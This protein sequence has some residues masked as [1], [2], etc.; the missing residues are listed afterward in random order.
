MR[1]KI[2]DTCFDEGHCGRSN[3]KKIRRRRRKSLKFQDNQ[4]NSHTPLL[5]CAVQR[6]LRAQI[7]FQSVEETENLRDRGKCTMY[8]NRSLLSTSISYCFVSGIIK[9]DNKDIKRIEGQQA[10]LVLLLSGVA[11]V[12]VGL[13]QVKLTLKFSMPIQITSLEIYDYRH[14][15]TF[16]LH[17]MTTWTKLR[18]S[19]NL[20][21]MLAQAMLFHEIDQA[22]LRDLCTEIYT[23]YHKNMLNKTHSRR[24]TFLQPVE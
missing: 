15:H 7:M 17:C 16:L 14:T 13:S 8:T 10:G 2:T 20:S 4:P 11:C 18:A 21:K 22:E 24:S 6:R 23:G 1:T 12:T 19:K 9:I 5:F 3:A